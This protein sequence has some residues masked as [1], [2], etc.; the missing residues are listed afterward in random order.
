MKSR[1][2]KP[3]TKTKFIYFQ[4]G[5]I[6]ALLC[7]IFLIE[8]KSEIKLK[9][10]PIVNYQASV[11]EKTPVYNFKPEKPEPI[12]KQK[13]AQKRTSNNE[14]LTIVDNEK[15]LDE[16][17]N[18]QTPIINKKVDEN[19]GNKLKE[20]TTII[21]NAPIHYLK[22]E[23]APVFPGCEI[24]SSKAERSSCFSS[25]IAKLIRK[26]FNSNI[27][28][29]LGLSGKQQIYVTFTVNENG[30]TVNIKAASRVEALAKEAER[31]T[32][33]L[34]TMKPGKQQGKNVSV[35]YAL[36]ISFTLY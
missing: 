7:S 6:A 9:K 24:Y 33:L 4:I 35:T 2:Q 26:K 12:K 19:L 22:V 31:V 13:S 32:K 16:L 10:D 29:D 14:E 17:F 15:F 1:E 27:A 34:P 36:P 21:D 28:E 18:N 23:E 3:Q 11:A 30:E 20:P 25:E 8:H 5:L